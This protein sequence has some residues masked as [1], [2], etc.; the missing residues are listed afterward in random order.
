MAQDIKKQEENLKTS[1][2]QTTD[3]KLLKH[4][5]TFSEKTQKN[6]TKSVG[7]LNSVYQFS[8]PKK[9]LKK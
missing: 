9:K 6:T 8:I 5:L 3:N 2:E 1:Q 7:S 4:I